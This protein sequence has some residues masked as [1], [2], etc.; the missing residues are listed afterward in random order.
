MR[1]D[2]A[3]QLG[4]VLRTLLATEREVATKHRLA[5]WAY[6]ALHELAAGPIRGQSELALRLQFDKSRLIPL[7]DDLQERELIS[8]A[9]DP[10]DRRV[11]LLDL[12]PAGRRLFTE[13]QQEIRRRED[14]LLASVDERQRVAFTRALA[15][16]SEAASAR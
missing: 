9:P 10:D 15:T 12:T 14:E 8:R 4:P 6:A 5:M 11:H 2:L 13:A 1:R 3:A 7:L 16:I